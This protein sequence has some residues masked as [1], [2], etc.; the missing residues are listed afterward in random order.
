MYAYA[1][2]VPLSLHGDGT[3]ALG[4]GKSWGQMADFFSWS[5]L[6]AWCGR[7]ELLRYLVASMLV[8]QSKNLR[9]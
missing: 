9:I 2:E 6:L 8:K 1:A 4:V 5:S 7:S 3:P